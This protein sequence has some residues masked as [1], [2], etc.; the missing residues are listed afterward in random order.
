MAVR[1]VDKGYV[2]VVCGGCGAVLHEYVLGDERN[3]SKYSGV[4]SP[5][6][7]AETY[8]GRCP[9]CGR[10]LGEP[11]IELYRAGQFSE[12]VRGVGKN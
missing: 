12:A 6:Q 5:R 3:T 9:E 2:F 8:G 10:S 1:F 11:E 4:P 7:V